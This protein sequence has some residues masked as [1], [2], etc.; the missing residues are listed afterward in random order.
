MDEKI[1]RIFFFFFLLFRA[2]PAAYGGSQARGRI[3]GIASSLH[4]SSQQRQILNPLIKARDWTHNLMVTSQICFHCTTIG[5]L[6]IIFYDTW[7]LCEIHILVSTNTGCWKTAVLC[8]PCDIWLLRS[9]PVGGVC[10]Y[11]LTL[12]SSCFLVLP[13]CGDAFIS[14]QHSK[15][16]VSP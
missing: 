4:H 2:A 10:V 9:C 7:T 6:R 12:P 11:P 15:C 13:D 3:G 1:K 14:G 16:W 5:T 8:H